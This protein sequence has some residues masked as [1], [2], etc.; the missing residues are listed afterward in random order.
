MKA[1]KYSLRNKRL[2][3]ATHANKKRK[4]R[5]RTALFAKFAMI[6][7]LITLNK[8]KFM[9]IKPELWKNAGY[10]SGINEGC[11]FQGMI[12]QIPKLSLVETKAHFTELYN[13]IGRTLPDFRMYSIFNGIIFGIKQHISLYEVKRAA[14]NG[15]LE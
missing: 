10:S 4:L 8:Y 5:E 12:M 3:I 11:A 13:H 6:Y 7:H 14:A 2:T 9:T 15:I 1:K